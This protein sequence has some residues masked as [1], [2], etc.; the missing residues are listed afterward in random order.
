ML[1]SF[2]VL[3]CRSSQKQ[4]LIERGI[5]PDIGTFQ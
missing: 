2:A 3:P 5:K 4:K 1:M